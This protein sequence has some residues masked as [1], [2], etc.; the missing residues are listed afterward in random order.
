MDVVRVFEYGRF[1]VCIV[2][3]W[4]DEDVAWRSRPGQ[5]EEIVI[6]C[7]CRMLS[8]VSFDHCKYAYA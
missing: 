7:F 1:H 5:G 8:T 4:Y 3:L 6:T 2:V